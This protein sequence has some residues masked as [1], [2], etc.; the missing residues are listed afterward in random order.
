[1]R[2]MR[3][4]VV[5]EKAMSARTGGQM[6]DVTALEFRRSAFGDDAESSSGAMNAPCLTLTMRGCPCPVNPCC[7]FYDTDRTWR[8]GERLAVSCDRFGVVKMTTPL[9]RTVSAYRHVGS[10][11]RRSRTRWSR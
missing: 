7:S 2:K 3:K 5:C 6:V 11:N 4:R 9:P 10:G 1:M 8:V